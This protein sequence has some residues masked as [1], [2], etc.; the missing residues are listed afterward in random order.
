M[1]APMLT[2]AASQT[3]RV[4]FSSPMTLSLISLQYYSLGE[5]PATRE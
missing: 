1:I 4:R 3:P 2:A 5:N